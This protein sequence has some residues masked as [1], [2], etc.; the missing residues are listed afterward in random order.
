MTTI[1][2]RFLYRFNLNPFTFVQFGGFKAGLCAMHT[3]MQ[4]AFEFRKLHSHI[5]LILYEF[6]INWIAIVSYCQTDC[7][8][9]SKSN[10]LP[11]FIYSHVPSHT[12]WRVRNVQE[13]AAESDKVKF[14]HFSPVC[15]L[16]IAL[17]PWISKALKYS[18][19][20]FLISDYFA[21]NWKMR[22]RQIMMMDGTGQSGEEKST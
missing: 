4:I 16:F 13:C 19:S 14:F 10:C 2:N 12:S 3:T 1:E 18:F 15:S 7:L 21:K 11:L 8:Y 5:G 6:L 9:Y 20:S 22:L 17:F